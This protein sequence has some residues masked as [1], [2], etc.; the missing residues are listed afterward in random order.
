MI[1]CKIPTISPFLD[2][3]TNLVVGRAKY[4]NDYGMDKVRIKIPPEHNI[5]LGDNGTL[6][7]THSL[8]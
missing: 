6:A 7:K 4:L 3:R 1:L 5:P 2:P 8:L